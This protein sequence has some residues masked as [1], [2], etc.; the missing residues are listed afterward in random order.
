MGIDIPAYQQ[1]TKQVEFPMQISYK[2]HEECL[3]DTCNAHH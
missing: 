3:S 1:A 2:K